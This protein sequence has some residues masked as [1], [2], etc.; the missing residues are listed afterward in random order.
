MASVRYIR[1]VMEH[2]ARYRQGCGK[3]RQVEAIWG[4]QAFRGLDGHA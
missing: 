1:L 2:Y 3:N 4:D